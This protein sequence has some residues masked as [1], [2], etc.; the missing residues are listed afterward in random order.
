MFR[1][2]PVAVASL[3]PLTGDCPPVRRLEVLEPHFPTVQ[4]DALS[5]LMHCLRTRVAEHRVCQ[6]SQSAQS[7]VDGD[8]P[9]SARGWQ[10]RQLPSGEGRRGRCVPGALEVFAL[11][12]YNRGKLKGGE[13]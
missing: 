6:T 11:L 10:F 13:S 7:E 8:S 12:C 5:H 9:H 1:L 4:L 3:H 2:R